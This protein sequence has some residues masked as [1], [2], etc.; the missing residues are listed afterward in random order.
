MYKKCLTLVKHY[1]II[2]KKEKERLK[3]ITTKDMA[4]FDNILI[5]ASTEEL[6]TLKGIIEKRQKDMRDQEYQELFKDAVKAIKAIAQEFP[7]REA[8]R[9]NHDIYD[10]ED[11]YQGL[12]GKPDEFE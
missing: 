12:I 9:G 5:T 2:K 4:S 11:I 3:M 6:N 10:W 8:V 7:G 1:D